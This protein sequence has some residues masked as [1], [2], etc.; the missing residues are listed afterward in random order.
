MAAWPAAG[1]VVHM[2]GAT[3][4]FS[5]VATAASALSTVAGI[6]VAA[7]PLL[8]EHAP[9]GP[10]YAGVHLV[11]GGVFLATGFLVAGIR[12]QV[13]GLAAIARTAAEPLM[14]ALRTRVTRL[15]I[16]LTVAGLG[17]TGILA[18]A[19]FAILSRIDE[20]FSVFG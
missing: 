8:A 15:M 4:A 10:V 1:S 20:G 2:P 12:A 18:I 6:L 16:L 7:S 11:V 17:L 19:I 3:R 14:N 5:L 9:E 13:L